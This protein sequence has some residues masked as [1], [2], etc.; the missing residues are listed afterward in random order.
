MPYFT[1]EYNQDNSALARE[2][3]GS[4]YGVSFGSSSVFW[5]PER[6]LDAD[7][8]SKIQACGYGWT[9]LDQSTHLFTWLGRNTSLPLRYDSLFSVNKVGVKYRQDIWT[10]QLLH[11]F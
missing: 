1:T 8:F 2:F 5:T 6:V 7:V 10:L 11:R 4:L 9:V 3:L